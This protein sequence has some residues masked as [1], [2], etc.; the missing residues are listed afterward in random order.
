METSKQL[1]YEFLKRNN[2]INGINKTLRKAKKQEF[3]KKSE[4]THSKFVEK[5]KWS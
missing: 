5:S 4:N 3:K 1:N 2:A